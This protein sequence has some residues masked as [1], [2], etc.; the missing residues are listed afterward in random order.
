MAP[1]PWRDRLCARPAQR[2]RSVRV[3]AW[4]DA[5]CIRIAPRGRMALRTVYVTMGIM[6]QLPIANTACLG[7]IA[8][9]EMLSRAPRM[10]RL[11]LGPQWR[12]RAFVIGDTTESQMSPA[13]LAKRGRGVGLV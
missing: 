4:T 3:V 11:L 2:M 5:R 7:R 8:R 10:P 12:Y 6:A 9:V 13:R 1:S